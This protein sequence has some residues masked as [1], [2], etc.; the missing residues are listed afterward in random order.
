VRSS[1]APPPLAWPVVSIASPSAAPTAAADHHPR[2]GRHDRTL[3]LGVGALALAPL[4]VVLVASIGIPW[5][6]SG[7]WAVIELRTRDVGTSATPLLGP[8][9]RYGW[10]HPG[11]WFFWVLAGPYR[12]LGTAPWALLTGA[13]TVNLVAAA[14]MLVLAWRRA[15]LAAVSLLAVGLT[16]LLHSLPSG[17]LWDPWNPWLTLLPFGLVVVAAWAA[18]DGDRAGL[19]VA[20]AASSF[21]VQAHVGF[22]L[23]A[24]GLVAGALGATAVRRRGERWWVIPGLVL[25]VAWLPVLLDQL[26]GSGNARDLVDH[27]TGDAGQAVGWEGALE[28]VSR[29]LGGD[30]PPWRGGV[31]PI[32]PAG[33]GVEGRRV[34]ALLVPLLVAAGVAVLGWRRSAGTALRLLATVAAATVLGYV[35]ISRMTGE[36][37]DYLIR[38][39]WVIAMAWTVALSLVLW[40]SLPVRLR[41]PAVLALASLAV[42]VPTGW[43]TIRHIDRSAVPG[44]TFVAPLEAV[45]AP[46]IEALDRRDPDV[47]SVAGVG[48]QVGWLADAMANA[49]DDQGHDVRTPEVQAHKF[50]RSRSTPAPDGSVEVVVTT[51]ETIDTVLAD[52]GA[53]EIARWD[54]LPTGERARRSAVE[55]EL[56]RQLLAADRDDLVEVMD[57]GEGIWEATTVPG[58]EP[59]LVQ[60]WDELH[61]DGFPVVVVIRPLADPDV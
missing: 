21:V 19:A 45:V 14:G 24:G 3:A 58:V 36:P 40:D 60:E 13:A 16:V 47:V 26:V 59:D 6:S 30:R 57:R 17:T 43:Q 18:V 9:S 12:L 8:Y 10:N 53:V 25:V 42:V 31:E 44:P 2:W 50:G 51:G 4:V 37:Y 28:L 48:P 46:T 22:A 41:V 35:S 52:P 34:G 32:S 11:P 39:W 38:W 29:Q 15:G 27:F 33:G 20:V 1:L 23:L 7:D 61:R 55:V 5:V 49:L 56:R 54:P